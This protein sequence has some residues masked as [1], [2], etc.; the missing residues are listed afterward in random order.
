MRKRTVVWLLSLLVVAALAIRAVELSRIPQRR[1]AV[2]PQLTTRAA[3]PGIPGA[4]YFP[5]LELAPFVRDVAAAK[6]RERAYRASAGLTGELPPPDLLAV[7]GGGDNGAFGAGLLAGWS[8]AGTRPEFKGVTGVSTG[9]LIAPFAF[10]GPAYDGVLKTVYT[11]L[12]PADVARRRGILAAIN[13]DGM[14]DNRP[15]SSLVARYI[16]RSFLARVAEEHRRG[17]L[18]LIGTTDLD[19]RQEVVWNM[20]AIAASGA[21]DALDL[22]RTIL[23]ASAS[24]PAAFPPTMIRVEAAGATYEEMHVDGGCSAQVFLYPPG[25]AATAKAMGA[26]AGAGRGGRVWVI[27]NAPLAPEWQPVERRTINIAG[28]AIA[29]LIQN[30]GIGDLYRIF[31]TAKHDG[32]DFNLAYIG[33]EFTYVGKKQEFE[34]AYM[35]KLY[36]YGFA[37]A[38]AGYPWKK[39]PPGLEGAVAAD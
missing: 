16:D 3:I 34:T 2:P 1:L 12:T 5:A 10:L 28:L 8:A 18:L 15:L 13:D 23:V 39:L 29:S 7:S 22:F 32:L 37:L 19:A 33:D 35:V 20:G 14:S 11:T 21:P 24:I 30:Q 31:L 38:R 25:L 4:R 6:E 17:R 9:A 36:D 27:R 26:T